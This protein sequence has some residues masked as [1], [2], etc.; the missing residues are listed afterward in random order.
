MSAYEY[1]D[2]SSD[3]PGVDGIPQDQD[4]GTLILMA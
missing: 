1:D 2:Q 3:R 4:Q